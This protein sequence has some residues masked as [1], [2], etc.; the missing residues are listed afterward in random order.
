LAGGGGAG[1]GTA[2]FAGGAGSAFVADVLAGALPD[3][4]SGG[5]GVDGGDV[6]GGFV[7]GAAE[8]ALVKLPK[9]AQKLAIWGT[10]RSTR[11]RSSEGI[12]QLLD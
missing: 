9:T 10:V 1:D 8:T 12:R 5:D 2:F 6:T 4:A 7:A 11:W 3:A